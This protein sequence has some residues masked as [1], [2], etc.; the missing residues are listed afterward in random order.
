MLWIFV[1]LPRR[2]QPE[3]DGRSVV[4]IADYF[5]VKN[6]CAFAYWPGYLPFRPNALTASAYHPKRPALTAPSIQDDT[7]QIKFDADASLAL[8]ASLPTEVVPCLFPPPRSTRARQ[9]LHEG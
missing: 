1:S 4:A 8:R 7:L 5:I 2:A 6:E 9:A 3:T